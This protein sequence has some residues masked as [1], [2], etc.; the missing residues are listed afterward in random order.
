MLA[1]IHQSGISSQVPAVNPLPFVLRLKCQSVLVKPK[2]VS[3]RGRISRR[4]VDHQ[5]VF[6][7][8][9]AGPDLP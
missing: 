2:L 8:G 7:G 9:L 1:T 6:R 3:S 4:G 5:A